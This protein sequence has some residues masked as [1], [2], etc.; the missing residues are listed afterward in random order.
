M[1]TLTNQQ[2][3]MEFDFEAYVRDELKISSR[4]VC[5]FF[6]R[7]YCSLGRTCPQKHVARRFDDSDRTIVCKHWLR[8]LCKKG[9]NC[10]YLHEFNMQKMPECFFYSKYKECS[11]QECFY[12]H[13][14]PNAVRIECPFYNRGFCNR[15]GFCRNL[16]L[17]RFI[18]PMYLFGFCPTGA[19]CSMAHPKY[20]PGQ[21]K[22]FQDHDALEQQQE[23]RQNTTRRRDPSP[24]GQD[25]RPPS[26]D[27][28]DFDRRDPRYDRRD[29]YDRRGPPRDNYDR[30][31]PRDDYDRRGY[32]EPPRRDSYHSR[33][34]SEE[35]RRS[36][37]D[38]R[39]MRR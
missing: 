1:A 23:D 18:C 38:R 10:E 9:D 7:G 33:S 27:Q 6:Q 28:R 35:Q 14:D 37:Y 32:R 2:F 13:I 39:P 3:D 17:R 36:S 5:Q 11:N 4:D 12:R 20:V 24:R 19:K 21:D 26:R 15:A 29:D 8:N 30:R 16:H 25:R 31:G 34:G 22:D